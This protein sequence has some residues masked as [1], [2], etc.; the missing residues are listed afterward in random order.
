MIV[1]RRGATDKPSGA[2][3]RPMPRDRGRSWRRKPRR[4]VGDS[5]HH[6]SASRSTPDIPP[7]I[8]NNY[9]GL[10]GPASSRS[11]CAWSISARRR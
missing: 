4:G 9:G 2:S 8:G 11:S 1:M 5:Q 10:S 7:A 6:L 3:S